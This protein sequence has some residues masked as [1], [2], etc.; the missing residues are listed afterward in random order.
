[1]DKN[2]KFK[3]FVTGVCVWGGGEGTGQPSDKTQDGKRRQVQ[4]SNK[5]LGGGGGGGGK[6]GKGTSDKCQIWIKQYKPKRLIMATPSNTFK[7]S[8]SGVFSLA[9][10]N[11][12]LFSAMQCEPTPHARRNGCQS[13]GAV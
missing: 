1:M 13:T 4:L 7:R 8:S 11:V 5:T 9:L 6:V 10:V 12:G 3:F 2:D